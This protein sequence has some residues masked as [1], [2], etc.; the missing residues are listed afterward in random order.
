[1]AVLAFGIAVLCWW[2]LSI[3]AVASRPISERVRH[4]A[5][6]AGSASPAEPGSAD[7]AVLERLYT[8]AGAL[9]GFGREAG[10]IRAYYAAVHFAGSLLPA[11]GP[12]SEREMTVCARYLAVR[13]D[14]FLASN[15]AC[16]RR[17]RFF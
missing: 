13:I 15:A 17:V 11:L 10:L 4:A 7:F 6:L 3:G 9:A 8:A 14:G 2:R 16:S 1:M 12:W 5:G